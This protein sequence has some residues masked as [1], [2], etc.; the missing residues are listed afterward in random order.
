MRGTDL[1]C[2]V[3][4][5]EFSVS[6]HETDAAQCERVAK[7][8]RGHLGA[9]TRVGLGRRG[10]AIGCA[11]VQPGDDELRLMTRADELMYADKRAAHG[12]EQHQAQAA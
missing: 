11:T 2:R 5:D 6:L 10:L 3:G 7:R 4:G 9:L 12:V 1:S 8:I